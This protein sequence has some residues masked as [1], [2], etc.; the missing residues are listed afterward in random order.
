[1]EARISRRWTA[2]YQGRYG[3]EDGENRQGDV[4]LQED[5][6]GRFR[7]GR[8]RRRRRDRG[9]DRGERGLDCPRLN[10]ALCLTA[11]TMENRALA[12]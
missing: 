6:E 11:P 12:K 8:R 2:R 4:V 10:V 3:T 7:R 9:R 5:E 1:M